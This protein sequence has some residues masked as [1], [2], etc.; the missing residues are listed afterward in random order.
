MGTRQCFCT[1]DGS[2]SSCMDFNGLGGGGVRNLPL[3]WCFDQERE[4]RK[5]VDLCGLAHFQHWQ[6]IAPTQIYENVLSVCIV[7]K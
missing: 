5:M 3:S 4:H 1:Q 6:Q 7:L 2:L